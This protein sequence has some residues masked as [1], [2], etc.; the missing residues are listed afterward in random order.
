M[1]QRRVDRVADLILKELADVLLRKVK[2]P[3]L[4]G[5]TLTRV[6]VSKDLGS[7]RVFY[8]VLA[9]DMGKALAAAGLESARGFVRRELGRRLHLRRTPDLVFCFD[10][11]LEHGYRIQHILNELKLPNRP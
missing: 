5:V 8:S 7:A 11:S 1:V 2:D 6:Q 10:S 4:S 9:D 3:R